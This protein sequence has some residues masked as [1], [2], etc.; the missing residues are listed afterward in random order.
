MRLLYPECLLFV[1]NCA[2]YI[3]EATVYFYPSTVTDIHTVLNIVGLWIYDKS[4]LLEVFPVA[5]STVYRH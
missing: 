5:Y 2:L 3:S 4:F 1:H